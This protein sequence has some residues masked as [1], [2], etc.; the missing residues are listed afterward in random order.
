MKSDVVGFNVS[1]L[2]GAVCSR[3]TE[4]GNSEEKSSPKSSATSVAAPA[5]GGKAEF[6]DNELN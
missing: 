2:K 6:I 1:D 4:V 3:V 5:P